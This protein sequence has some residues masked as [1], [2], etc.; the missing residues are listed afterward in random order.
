MAVDVKVN[1]KDILCGGGIGSGEGDSSLGCSTMV[2]SLEMV[3]I[4][5]VGVV[6]EDMVKNGVF[7]VFKWNDGV[8]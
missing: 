4:V 6:G 7:E 8:G 5:T 1:G 2:V 3:V